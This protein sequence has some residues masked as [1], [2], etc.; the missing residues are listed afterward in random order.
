MENNRNQRKIQ[1]DY[2]N[3]K[4]NVICETIKK[5]N[6]EIG[7]ENFECFDQF[8]DLTLNFVS[9]NI[10]QQCLVL[11]Q[12]LFGEITPVTI[13]M[14]EDWDRVIWLSVNVDYEKFLNSK[15]EFME[16]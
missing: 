11:L 12:K 7:L 15:F 1:E 14:P 13:Q 5:L 4:A 6:D 2:D 16:K 10:Q 3:F 8:G 9:K